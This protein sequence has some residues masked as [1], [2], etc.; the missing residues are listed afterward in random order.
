MLHPFFILA[1]HCNQQDI[2]LCRIGGSLP[3]TVPDTV[4]AD[5]NRKAGAGDYKGNIHT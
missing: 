1:C 3:L 4:A 2:A 5:F